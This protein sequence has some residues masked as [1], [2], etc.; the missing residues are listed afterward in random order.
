M[1]RGKAWLYWTPWPEI[2]RPE[3]GQ[4]GAHGDR[5]RC[6]TDLRSPVHVI[7]RRQQGRPL[8]GREERQRL[9]NELLVVLEDAAVPGVWVER[10]EF[11]V[12]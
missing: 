6:G 7:F 9:A 11:A 3:L 5:C 8:L 10:D 12:G 2:L 1:L 4:I